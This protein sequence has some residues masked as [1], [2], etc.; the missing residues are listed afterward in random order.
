MKYIAAIVGLSF[1]FSHSFA[2]EQSTLL[3]QQPALSDTQL[4]FV[5]AGDI[6]IANRDGS[7]PK[8]LTSHPAQETNPIFSPDGSMLAFT[9]PYDDNDDVYV[10]STAGGQPQRLT[11]HPGRDTPIGWSPDGRQV[12]L[13]SPRETDHGRSSQLYHV[14]L[15]GG[16]PTK[17]ME[18]RIFRGSYN[19]DA[20]QLAY[21]SFGSGYN[22]LFG[23]SAGWK[24]Y[25]GGTTPEIRVM[26]FNNDQV[27]S[28]PGAAAT[29][30]N[31]IWMGDQLYFLSDRTEKNFNLF[32]YDAGNGNVEQVSF[33]S[34]WDVRSAG[35]HNGTIV[36]AV[37]GGL[38]SLDIASGQVSDITIS[39]TPDLPQLRKQW[40]DASDTIQ[41]SQLSATGKRA[42]IT[43]RGEVFSVPIE[44]GS[45]R[46][47]TQTTG[48]RE[49]DGLWSP[50]GKQVAY[51]VE[52]LDGQT[53][54][55][56]DQTGNDINHRFSLG[57]HFYELLTWTNGDTPR[58][59]YADNHLGLHVIDVE[60]GRHQRIAVNARRD[61]FDVSVSPDG[62]WLAYNLE[63]PNFHRQ[64]MLYS[65][66]SGTHTNVTENT[67]DVASPAFDTEGKVLYF[68]A[69]TNSGPLQVG[70]NMTSQ[71]RPYRAGLYAL[72]LAGDG[73]SPLL[74]GS[75]D[76]EPESDSDKD[77]AIDDDDEDQPTPK[78]Q[79]DLDGLSD[80]IVGIP[81]SKRNYDNLA[82]ASDGK[83]YYIDRVQPGISSD[84]PGERASDAN[85]LMRFDFEEK[86]ANSLLS[87]VQGFT[88][89]ADGNYML[90]A[91]N[92]G[93]L[94]TTE[95]GDKLKTE[96]LD[97]SGLR[98]LVNPR[99]EWA[100]IFDEAWRMELEYY[101]ADT[102]HGLDWQAVYDKYQ[103][104]VKHV[105]RREDLNTL[106]VQMIAEL[107]SGHNRAGGGDVHNE[108]SVS[109]GL[110]GAN[111]EINNGRYRI[112][113]LYTGEDWNTFLDAPLTTPGNAAKEGEYI[114]SVNGHELTDEDNI[115]ALLQNMT[116]RQVS[117]RVGPNSNGNNARD[118][119]V[120][121]V[122]SERGL[123]LWS[124][125]EANRRA[126]DAATNGRVGYIYLPN[127]AG[128]GFTF[129][130]RMFF[131]QI[132]KEA[133]IIDERSNGGG[134]AANYITDVLSRRHLSGWKDRDGLI[135]N[136]P[137]GAL[138]GPKVMLIDQDAGSGGDFLPYSFRHLGIGK[139][140][141][142]RTW[143]GLIG[144]SA[145]PN[146][147]DGGGLT[148]P[149][150]RFFE[151]S[152]RWSIENEGVAPD[153]DVDLDPIAT[154]AGR[155]TQLE[156]AI[157]EI[158]D[159]LRNFQPSILDQAPPLP[160]EV[161]K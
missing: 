56:A 145:N 144:I 116:G 96:S 11:W 39:I 157:S 14:D 63:Q 64:L 65:F 92:N 107:Q 17:Q 148:V 26:N 100:Q 25:R 101:Y 123:R 18:A 35:G 15:D 136:T 9:A 117:L 88:L 91:K 128:A 122:G 75:G 13:V 45:T 97:L 114:L 109:T 150:F 81:V 40:K 125:V 5:Y 131:S 120:E 152:G 46:N 28:I 29:N 113:K 138:H 154:N 72:V 48:I 58:I 112:A 127:T 158:Q 23:G 36:Y 19:A 77:D 134:Q 67:A 82:V 24:G 73:K 69:S 133:L 71:E 33:E 3:L 27:M 49:Y 30:F 156:R 83:L 137:A 52:S 124:W 142:K 89:S 6:W 2:Q 51:I 60:S 147:M 53:L 34:D 41:G 105:G 149:F 151:P 12:A 104:L 44:D 155:D 74:T 141:G 99:E 50:D 118:I 159:Q 57:E 132:D 95:I 108:A 90:L 4:A 68:A 79:I 84:A 139:L 16:L 32:H 160:T 130:N 55:L 61:Q 47:L 8:R 102:L 115:F 59:V 129:F 62:E 70:L 140:I 153:I 93:S 80:R 94:V 7:D 126:V 111:L 87:G 135:Y 43:A 78:T 37:A 76:E 20:T 103:P 85:Q 146:L 86:E 1:A 119:T 121:P 22:G 106:I 161:G 66:A 54:V 42:L 38:K 98:T 10:I 110:L 21:M 31:P 143:G